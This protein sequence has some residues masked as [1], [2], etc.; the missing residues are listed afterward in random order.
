M[1]V[2]LG[3]DIHRLTRGRPLVLGGV[4]IESEYGLEGHSDADVLLHALMDALLGAAALG[5]IG[6]HFPTDDAAYLGASS[7]DLLA[8][9]AQLLR[10][11]KFRIVNVDAT[12]VA[13][14]PRISPH[15]GAMTGIIAGTLDVPQNAVS[16]KATT[17]EGLGPEGRFEGMSAH[18][19]ALL[20]ETP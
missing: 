10:E 17:N 20:E 6:R 14:R 9:V 12:L 8:R 18:A 13:E 11:S 15:I 7:V 2:G 16:I 1:R 19:I 4:Q 5:D 3:F